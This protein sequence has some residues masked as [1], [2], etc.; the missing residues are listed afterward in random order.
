MNSSMATEKITKK[1]PS[2]MV[3]CLTLFAIAGKFDK[4]KIGWPVVA[5]KSDI[6]SF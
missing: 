1:N 2:P 3:I 6:T 4:S 5:E